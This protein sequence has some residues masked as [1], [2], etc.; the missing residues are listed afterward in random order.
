MGWKSEEAELIA[1]TTG[2]ANCLES[3]KLAVTKSRWQP[4]K[5][6]G[7]KIEYWIRKAYIFD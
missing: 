5:L 2:C 7:E 4:V 3:V 1:N 6:Q